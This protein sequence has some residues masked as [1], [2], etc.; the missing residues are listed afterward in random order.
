MQTIEVIGTGYLEL[1]AQSQRALSESRY[2]IHQNAVD[3]AIA[4]GL[5]PDHKARYALRATYWPNPEAIFGK[6]ICF[7]GSIDFGTRGG[8]INVE[9]ETSSYYDVP[10]PDFWAMTSPVIWGSFLIIQTEF[11]LEAVDPEQDGTRILVL[12][13]SE[14]N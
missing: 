2:I 3:D 14:H 12:H 8:Y 10:P 11:R 5:P 6:W 13:M 9:V 1:L 4:A 7:K